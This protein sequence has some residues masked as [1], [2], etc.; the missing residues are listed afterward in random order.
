MHRGIRHPHRHSE[1]QQVIAKLGRSTEQHNA[2][3]G[4]ILGEWRQPPSDDFRQ[5]R[6]I[7]AI[8]DGDEW[9]HVHRGFVQRRDAAFARP[10]IRNNVMFRA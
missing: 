8:N 3:A 5:H 10:A 6:A 1:R 2:D 7:G 9:A 4:S